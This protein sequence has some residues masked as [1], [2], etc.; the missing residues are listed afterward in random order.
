MQ[1]GVSIRGM[2]NLSGSGVH[3]HRSIRGCPYGYGHH[4]QKPHKCD[5]Q[6]TQWGLLY[7]LIFHDH[8]LLC[9]KPL[10]FQSVF[11]LIFNNASTGKDTD[12]VFIFN[13]L[14]TRET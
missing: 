9:L 7:P 12:K 10:I 1:A 8:C 2:Q 14:K 13:D 6:Q 4:N 5:H 11:L 3:H